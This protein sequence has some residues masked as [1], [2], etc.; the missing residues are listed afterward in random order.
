VFVS[1][2]VSVCGVTVLCAGMGLC[3]CLDGGVGL[4]GGMPRAAQGGASGV[5]G[6]C[7]TC[8]T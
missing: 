8:M 4:L 6:N 3:A 2:C 5:Q 7:G 1:M